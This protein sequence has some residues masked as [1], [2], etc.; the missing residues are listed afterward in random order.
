MKRRDFIVAL[1]SMAA[2]PLV[3]RAQ[4]A[5]PV[6]GFL[7]LG[8]P[9][10]NARRL[11]GFRKGLSEAGFVEGQNVAVEYRWAEGRT[12]RLPE[13]AA[14]LVNRQVSVIATLSATQAALAAKAAT[15]TIPI[16]FQVGSD[17]V[18]IGLVPSLNRPGGNATGVGS[19]STQVTPK[20]V[21]LLRELVPTLTAVY[22]LANPTNPN[23]EAIKAEL[24]TVARGFNIRAQMLH[25]GNDAEIQAAIKSIP[26]GPGSGLVIA[27]DPTFFVRRALLATLAAGQRV[28]TIY[29]EREFAIDG[30]LMSYGTKSETAWEMCG[31]YVARILKGEKPADLPVAQVTAFEFVLNLRTAKAL[32]IAVPPTVLALADEVVE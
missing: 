17:P 12:E 14:D 31:G 1:G 19:L 11:S 26:P 4:Q 32:D 8:A 28:P 2:M 20:R 25:A 23:A 9:G 29:Y 27:N 22:V 5:R 13:L 16:V 10:P 3:A 18:T 6:I 30:G 21:Q 24:Q 15:R 7:H